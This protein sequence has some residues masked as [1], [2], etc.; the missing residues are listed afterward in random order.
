MDFKYLQIFV[1]IV[2]C[3]TM[4]AAAE[5]LHIAQSALSRH[6]QNM[7]NTYG[8]GPGRIISPDGTIVAH[9]SETY[10]PANFV[11]DLNKK[12]RREWLSLGPAMS[13][14]KAV[15]RYEKHNIE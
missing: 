6:L 15:Y 9:T 12:I 8:W 5:V 11:I 4:T 13:N 3:G 14:I 7:E 2:E 10:E 1:T